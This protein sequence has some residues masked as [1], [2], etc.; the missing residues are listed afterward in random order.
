MEHLRILVLT[1]SK[2]DLV[3]GD[4]PTALV[5]RL[6]S[7]AAELQKVHSFKCAFRFKACSADRTPFLLNQVLNEEPFDA[8]IYS[9]G[10]SLVLGAGLQEALLYNRYH[11]KLSYYATEFQSFL[12][13]GLTGQEYLPGSFDT[14]LVTLEPSWLY[15]RSQ[16]IPAICVPGGDSVSEGLSS[17]ISVTE[18]PSGSEPRPA[19]GLGNSDSALRILRAIGN[20]PQSFIIAF[21]GNCDHS[22]AAAQNLKNEI[23]HLGLN[24]NLIQLVDD[25]NLEALRSE[26]SITV[27]VGTYRS[28][29]LLRAVDHESNLTIFCPVKSSMRETWYKH[30]EQL[31]GLDNTMIVGIGAYENTAILLC[32]ILGTHAN[33]QEMWKKRHAKTMA[34]VMQPIGRLER[35][36][37]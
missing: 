30:L 16:W 26:S 4:Q 34:S 9:G 6:L 21:D 20:R 17:F 7:G 22:G 8:V 13:N 5:N 19:V 36:L 12:D 10:Y 31:D 25:T 14:S 27:F 23:N 29:K 18:N 11:K 32:R 15:G 1:V 35:S 3:D 24:G 37:Q 33:L 28:V 2:R